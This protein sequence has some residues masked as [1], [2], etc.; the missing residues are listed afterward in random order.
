[1]KYAIYSCEGFARE[2]IPSLRRQAGNDV[3]VVFVDDD[4]AKIGQVVH[5]CKVIS[6]EQLCSREHRDR[7]ISVAVADCQARYRLVEKCHSEGFEFFSIVDSSHL[8]FENVE[9]GE[10][11]IFCANT[12]T[13]GDAVIGRHFHCNIY[14]YVAHD[15]R[16][17]DF[18]TFAPRVNC[19]GRIE[20][21]D[22]AYIGTGAVLRQGE[23]NNKLRIGRGAIVGMGAVVLKDV[24]D[25]E[26]VAGNPA[27]VI[28]VQPIP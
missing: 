4:Q 17:G 26:V 2:V 9:V 15:C 11:A 22:F 18:V 13:T 12:M 7:R 20:V 8:R 5:G 21:D 27:R 16:I 3:D 14:S 25:G 19:N 24:G 23:H 10:G 6:F 1:M 28:R